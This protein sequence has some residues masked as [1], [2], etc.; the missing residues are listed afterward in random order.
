MVCQAT[1][2][3]QCLQ[4]LKKPSQTLL[5]STDETD[6]ILYVLSVSPT[7]GG[8]TSQFS[9]SISDTINSSS[10]CRTSL[11]ISLA[12]SVVHQACEKKIIAAA[13]SVSGLGRGFEI[14]RGLERK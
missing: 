3:P 12:L 4:Y 7:N 1:A 5:K 14:L 8:C 13:I 6:I 10:A 11:L 2:E 9:P